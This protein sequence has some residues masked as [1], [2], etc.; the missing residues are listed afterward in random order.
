VHP[1]PATVHDLFCQD[2]VL[3]GVCEYFVEEGLDGGPYL[4]VRVKP[5]QPP[6]LVALKSIEALD[7]QRQEHEKRR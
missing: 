3:E 6:V 5:D 7:L 2:F 1:D 4:M